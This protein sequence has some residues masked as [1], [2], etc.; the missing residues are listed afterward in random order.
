MELSGEGGRGT[1]NPGVDSV[2]GPQVDHTK[3]RD[4]TTPPPSK[5]KK[6]RNASHDQPQ[7]VEQV[8]EQLDPEEVVPEEL[9]EEEVV[10]EIV[11]SHAPGG[12]KLPCR[13]CESSYATK[14]TWQRHVKTKQGIE[15]PKELEAV[16][17]TNQLCVY[18]SR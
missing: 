16:G 6:E 2:G 18:C 5:K 12:K 3:P 10:P 13:W 7:Q 14:Y 1:Q 9:V 11:P 15:D 17:T 4:P 8:A